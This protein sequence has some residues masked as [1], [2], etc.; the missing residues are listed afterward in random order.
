VDELAREQVPQRGAHAEHVGPR[1]HL[2]RPPQ[3]QLGRHEGGSAEEDASRRGGHAGLVLNAGD[4]EVEHL[5]HPFGREKQIVG[6]DVPV[7]D[8]A[9]VG[10][11]EHIEELVAEGEHLATGQAT[12]EALRASLQ[13]L[14]AQQLHHEERRAVLGDVVVEHAHG[15][16]VE[17]GVG[18][19]T[20]AQ[21]AG[22]CVAVQRQF[23]VE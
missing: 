17:H 9:G 2:G 4:A 23:L 10:R 6:F 1:V 14:P 12:A 15:A 18:D 11:G 3:R 22:P 8:P 21:E 13:G 16:R 7:D 20:L 5:E 19:V